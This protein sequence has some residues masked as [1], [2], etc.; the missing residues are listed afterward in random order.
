M[1]Y[2]ES[3]PIFQKVKC[4]VTNLLKNSELSSLKLANGAPSFLFRLLDGNTS[5]FA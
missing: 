2:I 1:S 4:F 5:P 3:S